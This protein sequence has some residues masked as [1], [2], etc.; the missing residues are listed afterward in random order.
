MITVSEIVKAITAIPTTTE[1]ASVIPK[2]YTDVPIVMHDN[3][4]PKATEQLNGSVCRYS[5]Q[6]KSTCQED[7]GA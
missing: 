1:M 6:E 3:Y 2:K 7:I 5:V 4:N